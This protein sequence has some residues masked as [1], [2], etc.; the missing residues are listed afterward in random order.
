MV[1][2]MMNMFYLAVEFLLF[3]DS[4]YINV[5]LGTLIEVTYNTAIQQ[6]GNSDYMYYKKTTST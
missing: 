1:E 2:K 4:L 6:S 5:R 3:V